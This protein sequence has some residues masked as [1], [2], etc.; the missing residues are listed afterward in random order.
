MCEQEGG[1][2]LWKGAG[3]SG[4]LALSQPC[5]GTREGQS[6]P[7]ASPARPGRDCPAL[8]QSQCWGQ[9]G[10]PLYKKDFKFRGGP[11][12]CHEEVKDLEGKP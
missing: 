5:P 6:C 3:A 12:E 8:G 1:E 7:G 4:K 2:H 10:P 9:F 11:E